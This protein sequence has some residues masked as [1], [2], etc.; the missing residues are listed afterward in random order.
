MILAIG[1]DKLFKAHSKV[2]T[3]GIIDNIQKLSELIST[4]DYFIMPSRQEAFPQAP[5]EAMACGKPIIVTP[6]SG[7]QEMVR[8]YNGVRCKG[9]SVDD[10]IEGMK[11]AM[12]RSYDSAAIRKDVMTRFSPQTIA[13]QYFVLYDEMLNTYMKT[14]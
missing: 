12:K 5:I 6:V 14:R 9:F 1:D 10:I 2:K 7:T 13:K 4:S 11:T 3:V 8:D